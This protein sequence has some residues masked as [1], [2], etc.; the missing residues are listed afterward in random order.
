MLYTSME[1]RYEEDGEARAA[2]RAA[3]EQD[4]L[5]NFTPDVRELPTVLEADLD[6]SH[7]AGVLSVQFCP[8]NEA[9]VITGSG[10][11]PH[12]KQDSDAAQWLSSTSE[13]VLGTRSAATLC[14]GNAVVQRVDFEDNIRWRT[15]LGGGGVV[16]LA[17]QPASGSVL[18]CPGAAPP[19]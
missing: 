3:A 7:D 1:R 11:R 6:G 15:S 4:L 8:G 16:S 9:A 5:M 12:S 19:R 17:L 2:A 13:H 14:A 18:L 10:E